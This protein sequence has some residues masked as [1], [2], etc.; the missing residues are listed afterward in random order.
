[1]T[2]AARHHDVGRRIGPSRMNYSNI[3]I[4][5]GSG[6]VGSNLAVG[7]KT[8][9]PAAKVTALDNLRRRG[10]ELNLARLRSV[11]V[12]FLHGDIR[13]PEDLVAPPIPYDLLIECSAEASVLAGYGSDPRYV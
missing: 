10:S 8:R 11:G 9:Q 6:F 5:G 7:L 13:C 2:A 1:M 12:E 4:T 3:L